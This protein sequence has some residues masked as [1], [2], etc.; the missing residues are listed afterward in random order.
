MPYEI[1]TVPFNESTKGFNT[2]PLNKFILNKRILH[3]TVTFFTDQARSYW[4][5]FLEY[6]LFEQPASK[7][8]PTIKLTETGQRCFERLK[9]WRNETAQNEGIPPYVIAKN[10]QL[11]EIIKKELMTHA[12]LKQIH[13]FGDKKIEKYGKDICE[14]MHQFY[15]EST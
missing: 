5:V 3:Q 14:I 12:S 8:N 11:L 6:E 15:G 13:G 7:S 9:A 2:D 10:E 1:I 4:S